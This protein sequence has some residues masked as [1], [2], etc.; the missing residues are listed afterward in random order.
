MSMRIFPSTG[1][2]YGIRRVCSAW[3]RK[4]SS[5]YAKRC[6]RSCPCEPTGGRKKRGPQMEISDE[7]LLTL[8]VRI[9]LPHHSP[10]RATARCG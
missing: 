5:F 4:R 9:W 1:K 7:E 3:G 8:I 6:P 10:A 2:P